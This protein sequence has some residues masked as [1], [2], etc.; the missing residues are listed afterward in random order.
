MRKITN[1]ATLSK[2]CLCSS[3][4]MVATGMIHAAPARADLWCWPGEKN[5]KVDGRIGTS[6]NDLLG[7]PGGNTIQKGAQMMDSSFGTGG[8]I[9][10][11]VNQIYE[12]NKRGI[13]DC[14]GSAIAP[15]L[16]QS[17]GGSIDR[18]QCQPGRA[19]SMPG[20][21][22]GFQPSFQQPFVPQQGYPRQPSPQSGYPQPGGTP[23]MG[24]PMPMPQP[25]TMGMPTMGMPA[26][27]QPYMSQP[28]GQ[29]TGQP[30]GQPS[31][32][33]P[34]APQP[35]APQPYAPQQWR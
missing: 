9:L 27:Q 20:A 10:N 19:A 18:S 22:A 28:Y 4:L 1:L 25:M 34:Y 26:M 13:L 30:Y 16:P 6:G 2:P 24:A 14:V 11:G 29:P 33:Q 7:N 5:C 3:I 23:M 12:P 31:F 35:Y 32:S 8:A 15:G 17:I 21:G